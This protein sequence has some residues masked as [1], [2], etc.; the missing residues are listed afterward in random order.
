MQYYNNVLT[1]SSPKRAKVGCIHAA[2]RRAG[3]SFNTEIEDICH[4]IGHGSCFGELML[5]L[6]EWCV[7][8][9]YHII[10]YVSN[11]YLQNDIENHYEIVTVFQ[12][13]TVGNMPQSILKLKKI[14]RAMSRTLIGIDNM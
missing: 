9:V 14:F 6:R 1:R 10:I 3:E 7:A 2:E 4:N 12:T 13:R 5:H 11:I 8:L